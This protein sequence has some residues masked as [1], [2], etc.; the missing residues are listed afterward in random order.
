LVLHWV[1]GHLRKRGSFEDYL[2]AM[3]EASQRAGTRLHIVARLLVEPTVGAALE[4]RGVTVQ[5]VSDEDLNSQSFFAR[6]VAGL[7]P[8]LVHCRFGSPSTSL[9]LISKMLLVKRFV[10]TDH[11]SRTSLDNEQT[12]SSLRRLR[13]RMLSL[14]IDR[15]LPV[16]DFVGQQIRREVGASSTKVARLFNGID[17]VLFTPMADEHERARRR[18][19]LFGVELTQRCVLYVGQLTEAKGV[20]DILSI[21]DEVLRLFN[22]V[23]FIW[24]GDGPL[25]DDVERR[26]SKRVRYLGLR[27]D[28]DA[29]LPA[30]DLIV[31]PSRWHEAFCLS[32]AEAAAA[33]VPAIATRVGGVPEVVVDGKTGLL[34]EPGD[35]RALLEAVTQLLDDDRL[36]RAMGARARQRAEREFSL[37]AMVRSTSLHYREL[38]LPTL[39]VEPQP[40]PPTEV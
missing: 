40:F 25:A 20:D 26:A 38:G 32:V 15:Y 22:D 39:D 23:C 1:F 13:R 16:S 11:G 6:T 8:G 36:R 9:A 27:N 12:G 5:C 35:R 28:V 37:S 30:A 31:A 18:V 24:V 14:F 17:L 2:L 21:Q 29:L 4:D 33:G 34:V 7:R 3:A 10:F 19:A